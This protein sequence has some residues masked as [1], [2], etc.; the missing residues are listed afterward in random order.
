M[1]PV[2][3]GTGEERERVR[4]LT[5]SGADLSD[6]RDVSPPPPPAATKPPRRTPPHR[7][8]AVNLGL[9]AATTLTLFWS[10]LYLSD[11]SLPT[12]EYVLQALSFPAALLSILLAHELGHFL[13]CR[14]HGLDATLP[15][16]LPAPPYPLGIGTFGAFIRIRTPIRTRRQLLD[17]GAAGPLAGLVFALALTAVGLTLS[18][19]EPLPTGKEL[20]GVMV[21]GESLFFML[22]RWL[23]HGTL[24]AGQDVMLHPIALAGWFGTF[25]TALNLIPTS[26]LDGGHISHALLG[27]GS[28]VVSRLVFVSLVCFGALGD[29]ELKSYLQL[30]PA[31]GLCLM[32]LVLSLRPARRKLERNLFI[33]L[34]LA[35]IAMEY[36]LDV[37]PASG[38]W[39]VWGVLVYVIGLDHPPV[40]VPD[41]P[42][43][44]ARW[45]IG[46]L[47]LLALVGTFMPLPIRF[48]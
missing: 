39:L 31:V 42:L 33:A 32:A 18:R 12:L 3:A 41:E 28:R 19:V 10:G 11:S 34:L 40:R 36:Y 23:I 25:V 4:R 15:L 2:Q 38:M 47:C 35:Q 45:L 8:P 30:I 27:R 48:M 1:H 29:L 46:V 43:T 14:R 5:E 24:P 6:P 37:T 22:L 9:L 26:Q 20:A 7:H 21:F 13:A 16:F 17:I 44:P